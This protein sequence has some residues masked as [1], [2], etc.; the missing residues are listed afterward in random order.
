MVRRSGQENWN[1]QQRVPGP[2]TAPRMGKAGL[3]LE[4]RGRSSEIDLVLCIGE[5]W[6]EPPHYIRHLYS[7]SSATNAW[8][9]PRSDAAVWP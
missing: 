6:K 2:G 1:L 5:E 4:E 8:A 3:D 7:G 9:R